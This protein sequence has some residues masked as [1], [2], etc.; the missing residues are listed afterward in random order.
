MEV[1][2]YT[3]GILLGYCRETHAMLDDDGSVILI[4]FT[5]AL[6]FLVDLVL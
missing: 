6:S 4:S 3:F 5:W 2:I 1:L